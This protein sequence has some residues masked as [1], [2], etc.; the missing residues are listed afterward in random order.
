M[1]NRRRACATPVQEETSTHILP[2]MRDLRKEVRAM[3]RHAHKI[4]L[5]RA[6]G[7]AENYR[8]QLI[9]L[10]ESRMEAEAPIV[11][12]ICFA[13]AAEF[14]LP[15]HH[16]AERCRTWAIQHGTSAHRALFWAALYRTRSR[17]RTVP[18]M[19]ETPDDNACAR[20]GWDLALPRLPAEPWRRQCKRCENLLWDTRCAEGH[21]ALRPL[22][23]L[24]SYWIGTGALCQTRKHECATCG[25]RWTQHRSA[26]DPFTAWTI[27]R[28]RAVAAG[29]LFHSQSLKCKLD[30]CGQ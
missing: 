11:Q 25:T 4:A 18:Q 24:R 12:L 17:V 20:P 6:S 29:D 27:S 7:S 21:G 5:A 19:A 30:K 28:W 2:A 9:A 14:G 16:H 26:A 15:M 3:S 13:S 8:G 1:S 23:D 10:F 22:G